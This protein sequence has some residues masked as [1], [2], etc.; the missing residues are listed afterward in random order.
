MPGGQKSAKPFPGVL[1]GPVAVGGGH[2][3]Q[4]RLSAASLLTEPLRQAP[5]GDARGASASP[6]DWVQTDALSAS[7]TDPSL[8]DG[9]TAAGVE[10]NGSALSTATQSPA[11]ELPVPDFT[12]M[13]MS[14][15]DA[16]VA[17]VTHAADAEKAEVMKA[18][19]DLSPSLNGMH[20][21]H[22]TSGQAVIEG[23]SD[24]KPEREQGL[25]T[26]PATPEQAGN[27]DA[28]QC[29]SE[30]EQQA[31]SKRG[32]EQLSFDIR[33]CRALGSGLPHSLAGA[34]PPGQEAAIRRV[35]GADAASGA[36]V[37]VHNPYFCSVSQTYA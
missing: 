9:L 19:V 24:C 1:Q 21:P 23:E 2:A 13:S 36:A 4:S 11:D 18:D 20:S 14:S 35:L 37:S 29:S 6:D 30:A 26:Q 10:M 22:G 17:P 33:N 27:A 8:L 31:A 32:V 34:A 3:M 25:R 16:E 15:A 28:E 12:A 7:P 5:D